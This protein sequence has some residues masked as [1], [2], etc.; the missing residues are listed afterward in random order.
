MTFYQELQLNQAGS[1]MVINKSASRKEKLR[2]IAI[3]LFKI[4]I[5]IAFCMAV[6]IGYSKIFGSENSIV[7]VVVLLCVMTFRF[8]D[9]GIHTSHGLHSLFLMF[10]ILAF[11]PR[12]AN[13]SGL[14]LELLIHFLCILGILVLG[15]HNVLMS[16]QSTL[17]LGYLLL[18]GYDATGRQYLLR[19]LGIALGA[20]LTGVVFYRNHRHQKYKRGFG[21]LFREFDL[22]SSRSKW[23]ICLALG[24]STSIFL[25]G[26]LHIP[27]AM[28]VGIAVMSVLLPFRED[29][30]QRVRGRIPGNIVGGLLFLV[31]Y[32]LLPESFYSYIG[33][34]GGIGVGLSASYRWQAVFNSLGAISIAVGVLGLPGAIFFRIFNNAFGAVYGFLFERFFQGTVDRIV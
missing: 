11:G 9:F 17:V 14:G 4:F 3:Y 19:L 22:R 18:Y 2:H 1:K 15:C 32:T 28:W 29:L 31:I 8:A 24:I 16:N 20:I 21:H 26:L 23:Q 33:I 6:V 27:R 34:I 25:A 7:G 5:T 13:V 30:Q 10:L 12:L